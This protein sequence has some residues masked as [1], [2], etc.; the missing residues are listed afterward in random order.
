MVLCCIAIHTSSSSVRRTFFSSSQLPRDLDG[1]QCCHHIG[2]TGK[3]TSLACNYLAIYC[4]SV[5]FTVMLACKRGL[6]D[7]LLATQKEKNVT[8][9][10]LYMMALVYRLPHQIQRRMNKNAIGCC[11]K[12]RRNMPKRRNATIPRFPLFK[13]ASLELTQP[14]ASLTP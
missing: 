1:P 12:N 10:P 8:F 14:R 11:R 2:P 6:A 4:R 13:D 5:D 9:W 7:V 3:T